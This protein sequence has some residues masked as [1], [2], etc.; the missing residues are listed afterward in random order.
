MYNSHYFTGFMVR[1]RQRQLVAE[2]DSFRLIKT[3]KSNGINNGKQISGSLSSF[4]KNLVAYFRRKDE[5]SI[6]W[7][8]QS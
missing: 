5:P 8:Q 4:V 6:C 7:C 2:A 1:E 3:G